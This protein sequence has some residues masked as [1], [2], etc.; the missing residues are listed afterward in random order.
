MRSFRLLAEGC[1][2]RL[3]VDAAG[4]AIWRYL[5][6]LKD[7]SERPLSLIEALRL[8]ALSLNNL[9]Q[10]GTNRLLRAA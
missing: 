2:L 4:M 10:D 5:E 8:M 1:S 3:N 9:N 6:K 7:W